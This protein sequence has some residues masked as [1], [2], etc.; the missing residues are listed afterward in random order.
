[1]ILPRGQ[2]SFKERDI[3]NKFAEREE[4]ER[5][6]PWFLRGVP[7]PPL[8]LPNFQ[9]ATFRSIG[10]KTIIEINSGRVSVSL[11]LKQKHEDPPWSC[12]ILIKP[13]DKE[14]G[15]RFVLAN[16]GELLKEFESS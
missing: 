13:S 14:E 12:P 16:N 1:M 3:K 4:V 8:S 2:S 11:L 5:D 6:P 15:S 7:I 10:A 9:L